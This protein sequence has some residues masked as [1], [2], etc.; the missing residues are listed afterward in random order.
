MSVEYVAKLLLPEM[1]EEICGKKAVAL[2]WR[3]NVVDQVSSTL[4]NG[5]LRSSPVFRGELDE[6]T[7]I[8]RNDNWTWSGLY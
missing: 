7:V 2:R 8:W 3:N 5:W 1:R 6:A 4:F